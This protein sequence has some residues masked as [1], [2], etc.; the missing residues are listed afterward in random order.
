MRIPRS[1][2]GSLQR[3][4]ASVHAAVGLRATLQAIAEGVTTST[5]YTN[6]TVTTA[7]EPDAVDLHVEAVVGPPEAVALLLGTTCPRAALAEHLAG[8]EAW[9]ALRFW[10]HFGETDGV[11]MFVPRL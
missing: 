7:R 1:A 3:A 4:L 10:S 6:V 5:P 8:G 2:L 9:G 11:I